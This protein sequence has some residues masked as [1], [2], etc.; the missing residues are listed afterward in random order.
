MHALRFAFFGAAAVAYDH[1]GLSETAEVYDKITEEFY[2][3]YATALRTIAVDNEL[4][5]ANVNW[6]NW[7]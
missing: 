6:K 2:I 7:L 3:D 1:A 5:P 4:N